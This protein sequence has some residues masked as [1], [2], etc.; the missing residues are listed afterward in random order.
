MKTEVPKVRRCK[1]SCHDSTEACI[2]P[3]DGCTKFCEPRMKR[4]EAQS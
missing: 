1:D 2:L 3:C 4:K